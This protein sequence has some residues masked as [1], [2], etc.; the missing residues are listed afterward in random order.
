MNVS[1]VIGSAGVG[2]LLLAFFLTLFG[3]IKAVSKTYALM[4]IVGS[5]LSGVASILINY[6]P[7]IIL[8]FSWCAVAVAGFI[9]ILFDKKKEFKIE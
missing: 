2:L 8:E 3:I 5:A 6:I 9:K 1:V 7:F 4:N